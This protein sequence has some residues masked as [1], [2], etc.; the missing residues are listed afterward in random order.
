MR[1]FL[2]EEVFDGRVRVDTERRRG[3]RQSS[4]LDRRE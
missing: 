2:D 3:S 4:L 1:A